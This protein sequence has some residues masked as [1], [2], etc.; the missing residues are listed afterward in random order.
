MYKVLIATNNSADISLIRSVLQNNT[1][2]STILTATSFS[3]AH[4]KI[5]DCMPDFAIVDPKMFTHNGQIE[6]RHTFPAIVIGH[7]TECAIKA[8][9]NCAFDFILAPVS[10]E[11][12]LTSINRV[13]TNI[14]NELAN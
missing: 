11:R 4:M 10:E 8:F 3:E 14:N 6:R 9:D 13:I 7:E 2:I 1:L 12:L 5:S